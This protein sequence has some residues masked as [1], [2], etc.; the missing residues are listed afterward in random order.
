MDRAKIFRRL[1][2]RLDVLRDGNNDCFIDTIEE[3]LDRYISLVAF[4]SI[5]KDNNEFPKLLVATMK[6][7]E[8]WLLE[9]EDVDPDVVALFKALREEMASNQGSE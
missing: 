1:C 7:E 4:A 6:D 3:T 5:N 8:D 2:S 9:D